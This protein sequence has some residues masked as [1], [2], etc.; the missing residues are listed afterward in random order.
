MLKGMVA[1]SLASLPFLAER[2]LELDGWRQ[3]L[4]GA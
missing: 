1:P 4:V 3:L 2:M